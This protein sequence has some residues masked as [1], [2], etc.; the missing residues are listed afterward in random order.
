MPGRRGQSPG[1]DRQTRA[2]GQEGGGSSSS[3]GGQCFVCTHQRQQQRQAQGKDTCRRNNAPQPAGGWMQPSAGPACNAADLTSHNAAAHPNRMQMSKV[4]ARSRPLSSQTTA[5]SPPA[6]LVDLAVVG[7]GEGQ[8]VVLQLVHRL[9]RLCKQQAVQSR[10][11]RLGWVPI[12]GGGS[13]RRGTGPGLRCL[14]QRSITRR[15]AHPCT[16]TRWRP[17]RPASRCPSRCHMRATASR[18]LRQR[19]AVRFRRCLG[20]GSGEWCCQPPAAG[21][22]GRSRQQSNS[23]CHW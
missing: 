17:G 9:G 23:R 16:C 6:H 7:A 13:G 18:P 22:N 4:G 8:A 19:V 12:Q 5:W 11:L 2:A 15:S 1:T 21:A 20:A 3:K 10:Q 14:Q